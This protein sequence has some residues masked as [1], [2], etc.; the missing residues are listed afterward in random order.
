MVLEGLDAVF[1]SS[2]FSPRAREA[3]T[4]SYEGDRQGLIYSSLAS[5]LTLTTS[6]IS[7]L[8]PGPSF[9]P[10][11]A[12]ALQVFQRGQGVQPAAPY[13]G[14]LLTGRPRCPGLLASAT[15]GNERSRRPWVKTAPDWQRVGRGRG[16]GVGGRAGGRPR[17]GGRRAPRSAR[18]PPA[19]GHDRSSLLLSRLGGLGGRLAGPDGEIRL[20]FPP[21]TQNRCSGRRPAADRSAPAAGSAGRAQG[22]RDRG[23]AQAQAS[24][25]GK[26][27]AVGGSAA[28]GC[29]LVEAGRH[30]VAGA[31]RERTR[32]P[33]SGHSARRCVFPGPRKGQG[34]PCVFV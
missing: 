31:G 17:R 23:S 28:R 20:L 13:W 9:K 2:H 8:P 7:S 30:G 11:P 18:P 19:P 24:R 27:G 34:E 29:P 12:L 6:L 32:E 16:P 25:P 21:G 10:F 4:G 15:S 33:R 26:A 22:H 14:C 3:I 5:S 1:R